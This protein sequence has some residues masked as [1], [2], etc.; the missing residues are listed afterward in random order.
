M[1]RELAKCHGFRFM[2][3]ERG[4]P[5]LSGHFEYGESG[6]GCQGLGYILD[7]DFIKRFLAVFGVDS[8]EKT[9]G[10][11][12]WVIHDNSSITKIEPLRKIDGKVFDILE[13]QKET[14]KTK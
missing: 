13:W 3:E 5:I 1:E 6:S 14:R 11:F 8:F 4:F 9:D 12:C 2:I 7:M 10:K